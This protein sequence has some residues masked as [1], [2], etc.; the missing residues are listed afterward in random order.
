MPG[1]KNVAFPHPGIMRTEDLRVLFKN[2][3]FKPEDIK[4]YV[5]NLL[6]KFEV[7]L[8]WDEKNLLI[9]SLLPTEIESRQKHGRS[10]VRVCIL[11]KI[12]TDLLL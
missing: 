5:I 6:N 12:Y 3:A 4:I 8:L 10:D 7:A 2:A 1:A 9:P 11:L